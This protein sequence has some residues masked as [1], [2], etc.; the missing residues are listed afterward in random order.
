MASAYAPEVLAAALPIM[1]KP[2]PVLLASSR[3]AL[4]ET[5]QG[6]AIACGGYSL[7]RPGGAAVEPGLAH[8]RHFATHPDFTGRGLGRA[9]FDWSAAGAR[10][11][12]CHRFECYA[13][14]NA[15]PFYRSLGFTPV[16]EHVVSLMG[17]PFPSLLM[18]A[19]IA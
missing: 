5:A 2:N 11:L 4:I 12:G 17:V 14:L 10:A 8:I 9:V 18:T 6:Q 19:P 3:F 15:V 16:R 7:E 13:A 1:T